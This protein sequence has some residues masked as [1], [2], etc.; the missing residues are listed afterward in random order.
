MQKRVRQ[1]RAIEIEEGARGQKNTNDTLNTF[2]EVSWS[3][4]NKHFYWYLKI[5]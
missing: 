1:K 2:N 3:A 5:T 4:E